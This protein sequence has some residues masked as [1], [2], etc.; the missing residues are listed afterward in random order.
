MNHSAHRSSKPLLCCLLFAAAA[1]P[2]RAQV[3]G[4]GWALNWGDEFDGTS[5][6]SA[7]WSVT[8][9]GRRDAQNVAAAVSVGSGAL[10]I[11]TYT[12]GGVHKTGFIGSSGKFDNAFG[13]WEARVRFTT[14]DGMWS[15]FWIQSPTINNTGNNP[16]ANGT[17]IDVVEH[18]NRDSGATTINNRTV[19]N[20]HWDGY[21]ADH[22]SVGSG[23][24]N[25]P[26]ATALQGNWHTYGVLWEPGINRF[27]VDGV[28]MWSQST[29]VSHINHF[30]Y[31]TSEVE[32]GGW[33]YNI[34]SG[35][36][37]TLGTAT[38]A[39]MEVDWVRYYS[40][41]ERVGNNG[42]TYGVGN[43][44]PSGNASWAATGGRNGGGAGRINPQTTSGANFEQTV[45]GLVSGVPYILT[46]YGTVGSAA[47]PELRIGVKNY[48]GAQAYDGI[49]S[50]GFTGAS[51]PF[52]MGM[53]NTS[54]RIF[55]WVPTQYGD[56]YADDLKVQRAAAT[57]DSGFES[58]E[59]DE[60]WSPYGDTLVHSWTPVRS[61][62]YAF[63]FNNP[64]ADRGLEQ[65]IPGLTPGATYRLSCWMRTDNQSLSLGVKNH[66]AAP[67]STE[68][69]ALP[70]RAT[71]P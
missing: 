33:A 46:G 10:T 64:A 45:A 13:Y 56:A 12:E 41:A 1:S 58:G 55:A 6:D 29:A 3:P 26:G 48:G 34:P 40:R 14:R 42:W 28:E 51:V 16:A 20:V 53:A 65:A 4:D 15:A 35:G 62:G 70:T 2:L 24:M 63:R 57:M 31:L 18:R 54:A 43:W 69:G 8:T 49:S 52:T 59:K 17:E 44:D 25:N 61:G 11:S 32:T 5:L 7:R 38:N 71:G 23:L 60:F 37:G 30:I 67:S 50:T 47:W 9:G 39:K 21:G 66:G 68:R 36:Y 19:S 22:K 27:Y